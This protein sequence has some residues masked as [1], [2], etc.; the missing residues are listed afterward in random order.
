MCPGGLIASEGRGISQKV[1][2]AWAAWLV[3]RPS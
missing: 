1:L 3:E 2:G